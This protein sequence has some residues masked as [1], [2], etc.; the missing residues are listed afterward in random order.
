[1]IARPLRLQGLD[2]CNAIIDARPSTIARPDHRSRAAHIGVG[3]A[4]DASPAGASPD[5]D[6]L[7][8]HG[9]QVGS[10]GRPLHERL[11]PEGPLVNLLGRV[12]RR[13][14]PVDLGLV[15]E[16]HAELVPPSP[17]HHPR[18]QLLLYH[19]TNPHKSSTRHL[20]NHPLEKRMTQK[21]AEK[22]SYTRN[23]YSLSA[24]N[25]DV[26][27]SIK[28]GRKKTGTK[29]LNLLVRGGGREK[30]DSNAPKPTNRLLH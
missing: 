12:T 16:P 20:W 28:G 26:V 27:I 13:I 18:L 14:V 19:P 3:E 21:T 29:F 17:V 22:C 8:V 23:P 25:E 1:M 10:L 5:G 30:R 6:T 4:V 24:T 2:D 7:P 9:D 11:C 15:P